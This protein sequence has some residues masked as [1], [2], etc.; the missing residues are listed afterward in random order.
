MMTCFKKTL[1]R[2]MADR[3]GSYAVIFALTIIPILIAIG[4][5]IDLSQAYVAKQRLTSPLDA[6]GLAIGSMTGQTDAHIVTTA[7][8][9]S[10]ILILSSAEKC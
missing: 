6:A 5:A 2:F 7:Q 1:E 4:A 3:R 10:T 9:S 8:P